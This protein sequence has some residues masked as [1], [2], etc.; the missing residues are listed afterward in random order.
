MLHTCRDK[1]F[2]DGDRSNGCK[3]GYPFKTSPETTDSEDGYPMY[4]RR[5]VANGGH[6]KNP[7]VVAHNV[8]LLKKYDCHMNIQVVV[9]IS[10]VKYLFKYVYKGPDKI[11][12]QLARAADGIGGTGG[13]SGGGAQGPFE[14]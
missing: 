6:A 7:N 4:R 2:K 13:G 14:F 8:W 12:Y 11:M 3:D 10:S 1:C 5:S 9:S